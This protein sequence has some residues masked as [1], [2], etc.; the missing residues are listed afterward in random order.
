M[1]HGALGNGRTVE[2]DTSMSKKADSEGFMVVYPYGTGYGSKMFLF[3][4]A[5]S[6]CGRASQRNVDD[7]AFIRAMIDDLKKNYNVDN[8]RIYATGCSNGGM[9]AYRVACELGDQIA[10]VAPVEACMMWKPQKVAS[11]VSVLALNGTRDTVVPYEGGTGH[12]LFHKVECTSA[13]E[14]IKF[15]AEQDGCNPDPKREMFGAIVKETYAGGKDGTEVCL[16]T[17]QNRHGWPMGKGSF[18]MNDRPRG[19]VS[20]TDLICA[21]FKTH[22]K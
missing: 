10:A 11:A 7:I 13:A 20:A 9:F 14:C 3:S 18:F 17:L 19:Q 12:Y 4:N 15:W 1:F 16:Y 21:F 5:G 6:C 2:W 22:S 8:K